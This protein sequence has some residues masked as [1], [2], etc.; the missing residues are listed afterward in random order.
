LQDNQRI[1]AVIAG[2]WTPRF[3]INL[4]NAIEIVKNLRKQE[5]VV[6]FQKA[7]K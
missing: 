6:E 1:N 2:K 4:E 5:L 7:R 3:P